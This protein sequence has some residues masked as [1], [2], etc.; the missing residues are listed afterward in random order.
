MRKNRKRLAASLLTVAMTIVLAG[1]GGSNGNNGGN[2]GE[3]AASETTGD[4][5]NA[6]SSKLEPVELSMVFPGPGEPKD[7]QAVTDAINKITKEKINATVKLTMIGW[8]AWTQQTTLMLSGNEKIDLILSGLGTYSQNVARGQYI[9]LDDL[10]AKEG[11]GVKQALDDLDPAFLNAV[12]IKGKAYAVPSIRDLAADYGITMRKDLVDKYNIDITKIKSY[13]DLDAI[14]KTIKDNEP[15]MIPTVKYGETIIDTHLNYYRD[16]LDDGFG[17]LPGLDNGM[18][19]VDYYETPEYKKLLDTVRRWYTAGYIAKDAATS[20]E[21]QYNLVKA[22]KAF[23]FMSH[24]K[25]G[26]AEQESRTTGVEMVSAHF[27]PATTATGN[28]T[29]IMWSIARNSKNPERAMMLLNLI[30]TDKDLINLFDWGIE[31]KHYAKTSEDNIIEFPQGTDASS[32]GYNLNM[33]WMFGN[34]M[35]SYIFKGDNPNLWKDLA[36]FNKSSK[37]SKA[38]G[39][40]YNSEPVK[41]EVAAV[42]N[43]YDQYRKALETGTVDPEVELPKYIKALKAAGI[44]KIVAEKQKQLDEW[45]KTK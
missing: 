23:S 38:L 40:N 19:V 30:Y 9:E 37:K 39:F 28:I 17:V 34:Q 5:G 22:G 31:G 16:A 14:F 26:I 12:K 20:T 15:N 13:D 36:A 42:R 18:K 32:N 10:L 44:D 7:W 35:L 45:V 43:V 41:T 1:C 3:N 24:M 8:A 2:T 4:T 21:T 11:Q 29:S 25:P 27:L 33:G 6:S